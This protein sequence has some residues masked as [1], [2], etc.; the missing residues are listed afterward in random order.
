MDKVWLD[1]ES[2]STVSLEEKGLDNYVKGPTQVL[3]AAYA[4]NDLAPKLWQPHLSPEMPKDLKDAL[5]DPFM[6]VWSWNTS[7]ERQVTKHVLGI[8]KPIEEWRDPM[9]N[10]RYLGLPGYLEDAGKILG[11][12]DSQA[13]I[14]DGSRLIKLFCEP[15]DSGGRETLF[16]IS[17]PTFNSWHTHPKDWELFCKYCKQDVVAE[18]VLAQ[19]MSKFPLP[20]EELET[21]FLDQHINARG[22]PVDLPTVE[23]ARKIVELEL[24]PLVA[25][26]KELSGLDNVNSRNQILEWVSERGYV[27]SS[28]GKDFVARALAG[29]CNLTP[30]CREVLEIRGQTAKS[31]VS[32][33]TALADMTSSDAR[34]RHQ[35]TYYGA[36]TGRWA[37]HGVN[38]GNLFKPTKEVE[39]KLG[40]AVNLVRKMD[41]EAIRK[42]FSKPMEVAASV[43]RSAFRA[44]E[45]FKF[46]WAD[47]A[48]IENRGL[49]YLSHCEAL[50]KVYEG[51]FTYYGP[52]C[53]EKEILNGQEFALDPYLMFA[54][55]MFN[56]SYRDLWIEW[57]IKGDKTK[58]DLCKAPVLGGGYA[59]G[60]GEEEIDKKTGLPYWTGLMGYGR[61]MGIEIPHDLAEQSIKV[62]REEWNEVVWLWKDMEKAFAFAVRHPG[63]L[64]GVGLPHTKREEEYFEEKGRKIYEPIISFLCHGAKILEMILPSG[65]SLFYFDPRVAF[66]EKEWKG[67]KYQQDTLYYKSKDPKTK[68]WVEMDTFGGHLVENGDQ[69]IC[70]DVLVHG[71]KKADK[72]GFEI[73]G[74]TYDEV[75]TL[76]PLNSPLGVKELCECLTDPPLFC[77]LDLPLAAEGIEDF[78]YHK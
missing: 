73:C 59:L 52:D 20:Q 53:P 39:N 48:G 11:L 71:M 69:A 55:R 1:Y 44:P 18:R 29:E 43:Q 50:K 28:L 8:D 34:I 38:M 58:R 15:V 42:E 47:L 25:R 67:R 77:G 24:K 23:G 4:F 12:K 22:W 45:G 64:T 31:S 21:W 5:L 9:C 19:K 60:A 32:K 17:E 10:A 13:K 68:Q 75:I 65:R 27:F 49:M 2:R 66:E 33:Y 30:E 3:L 51:K 41:F 40:L 74:S 56:M 63:H 46:V 37:A 54:V 76:V 14:K 70:R 78:I 35:Y 16:G 57:K 7:F 72:M 26:L 6:Q 62:L 36:H 61:K